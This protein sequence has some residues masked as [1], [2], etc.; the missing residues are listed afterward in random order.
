MKMALILWLSIKFVAEFGAG[1]IT[2]LRLCH[3]S[4]LCVWGQS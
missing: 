3:Q 4:V 2:I 1:S